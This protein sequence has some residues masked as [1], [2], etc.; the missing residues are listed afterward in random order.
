MKNATKNVTIIAED[1]G[2]DN[3]GIGNRTAVFDITVDSSWS[4]DQIMPTLRDIA[5]EYCL[6]EDGK[7]TYDSN[8]NSFNIGDLTLYVPTEIFIKHG[9]YPKFRTNL[10]DA[11]SIDFNEQLVEESDVFQEEEEQYDI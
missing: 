8:C 9:I 6:T 10:T 1:I 4:E 3:H 5:K 7:K 2:A 11:I